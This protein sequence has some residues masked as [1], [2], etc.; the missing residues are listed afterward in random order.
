MKEQTVFFYNIYLIDEMEYMGF[1]DFRQTLMDLEL[2]SVPVLS[3][4]FQ[5]PVDENN[6]F[7]TAALLKYAEGKSVLNDKVEREGLVIRSLDRT[8]S[9]K[10]I[11]NVF[12]LKNSD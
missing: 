1:Y 6:Q 2:L 9:F 7:T 8:I 11:S 4:P 10:S 5:F 12:L 3:I